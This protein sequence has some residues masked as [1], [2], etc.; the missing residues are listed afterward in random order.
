MY[1]EVIVVQRCL[2]LFLDSVQDI[3]ILIAIL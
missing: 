1:A 2:V 3:D